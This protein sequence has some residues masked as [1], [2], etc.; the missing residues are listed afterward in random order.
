MTLHLRRRLSAT[1]LV[2]LTLLGAGCGSDEEGTA[3]AGVGDEPATVA[4]VTPYIA[5]AA[6]KEVVDLFAAEG[7]ERGW[8]VPVTD[9]AGDF[10]RL[11]SAIQDA[12]TQDVDAIVLGMGDP[13]QISRG[14]AAASEAGIP[15]FSIDGGMAEGITAL[16]TSDNTELGATS[17]EQLVELTGGEGPVL[18]FTHDPHPGVRARAEAA[19]AVFE[20]AGVEVMDARHVEVPGPVENARS[21]MQDLLTANP[22][23]GAIRG[24]WAGWDEPALGVTQA[25]EAA[26]RDGIPV[27]GVDGQDFALAEIEKDGPFEATVA[28]DWEGI[29]AQTAELVEQVLAGE[30]P[31]QREYALPGELITGSS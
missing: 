14:L 30:E 26:G 10:D 2:G 29:A 17:A 21:T 24:V 3:A 19:A 22:D 27:V 6:T 8:T 16:V 25:I 18:M 23:E 20:E 5:N 31:E 1:L 7:R 11:N 9:T 15:V 13:T 28:Q 12:V 4:V